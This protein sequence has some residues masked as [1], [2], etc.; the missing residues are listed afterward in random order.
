MSKKTTRTLWGITALAALILLGFTISLS[1]QFRAQG[2]SDGQSVRAYLSSNQPL[3]ILLAEPEERSLVASIQP[4][5]TPILVTDYLRRSGED[6]YQ[7]YFTET[8]AGWVQGEY[9][10]LEKP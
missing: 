6:W 5:G 4:N 2:G 1:L 7:I 3:I 10:S 9:L 8:E